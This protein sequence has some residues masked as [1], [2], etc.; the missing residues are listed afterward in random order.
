VDLEAI[1]QLRAADPA[2]EQDDCPGHAAA[3]VTR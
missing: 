2:G 3:L 1:G